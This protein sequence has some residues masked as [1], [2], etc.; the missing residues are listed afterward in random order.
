MDTINS[1]KLT[2]IGLLKNAE[3]CFTLHLYL[4]GKNSFCEK[5]KAHKIPTKNQVHHFL[6]SVM[7]PTIPL[8]VAPKPRSLLRYHRQPAPTAA[9]KVSP[10]CLGAMGFSESWKDIMGSCDK[11]ASLELLDYFYRNGG[12]FIDMYVSFDLQ[13]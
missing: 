4:K 2:D 1:K 11:K 8:G 5:V 7:V 9:M 13:D 12:N 6:L 3:I 10:L